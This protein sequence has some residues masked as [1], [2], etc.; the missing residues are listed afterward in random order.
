MP[1]DRDHFFKAVRP[2][3]GGAL[4]QPQVDGLTLILN[5]YEHRQWHD[6]RHLAY[7]LA[8]TQHETAATMQPIKEYGGDQYFHDRYDIGGKHPEIARQLGNTQPGDGVKFCGR[9]YVQLTGRR[10]YA[11]AGAKA[12]VDLL[13]HPEHVM[14]PPVAL[15]V[16]F[17]GMAEGWF[18]GKNLSNY[19]DIDSDDPVNARRIINGLDRAAQIATLHAHFLAALSPA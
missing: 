3:F 14:E 19:F 13:A 2:Q 17:D 7:I 9:G 10:N 1:L 5:E 15:G 18:T 6:L 16:L 8:T 11:K 12:G 4:K